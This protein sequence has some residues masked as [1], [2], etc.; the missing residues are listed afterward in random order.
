MGVLSLLKI[1]TFV[2]SLPK[3]LWGCSSIHRKNFWFGW[4]FL[5]SMSLISVLIFI[6]SFFFLL[7]FVFFSP[8]FFFSFPK[9]ENWGYFIYFLLNL[10]GWHWFTKP[11]RFQLYNLTKDHLYTAPCTHRLK[12]SLFPSSFIPPLPSSPFP[13]PRFFSGYHCTA[14]CFYEIYICL[15]PPPS[16]IQSP[17][18]PSLC[19]LSVCS[20][21]LFLFCLSVN[22]V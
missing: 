18:P 11:Y 6:I 5:F 19:Q 9:E 2:V 12:R 14:V 1:L 8:H 13:C 10:L 22:F 20:T 4:F 3:R 15:I 17:N 7:G 21:P 16:F